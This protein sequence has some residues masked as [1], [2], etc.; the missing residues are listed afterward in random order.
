MKRMV[1]YLIYFIFAFII[2]GES[3]NVYADTSWPGVN[4]SSLLGQYA[5]MEYCVYNTANVYTAGSGF[6]SVSKYYSNT[7]YIFIYDTQSNEIKFLN[8]D[9]TAKSTSD[10]Y[11]W[12][13]GGLAKQYIYFSDNLYDY[14][15]D[16]GVF[17][18][19]QLIFIETSG[20][21]VF[22][23]SGSL[24]IYTESEEYF[25]KGSD[26]TWMI[27][28]VNSSA[29]TGEHHGESIMTKCEDYST[30]LNEIANH[31]YNDKEQALNALA[32]M[33]KSD[34]KKGDAAIAKENFDIFLNVYNQA[35]NDLS[36]LNITTNENGEGFYI[37]QCA[38][39]NSLVKDYNKLQ[40]A[41]S[42]GFQ[43]AISY[44]NQI[45]SKLNAAINNGAVGMEEDL[46]IMDDLGETLGAATDT[47]QR[48]QEAVDLGVPVSDTSCEGLLG[49]DLLDDI[50]KVLTLLRIAVPILLIIL[51]S[52][53][54]ASAVLADDQ[55]ALKKSGSKF[56]KRCIIAVAIFFVPSIIMYLLSWI[57]KIADVSCDIRLW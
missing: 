42:A 56:V 37:Q 27:D 29:V 54:F 57:D 45:K 1:K 24:S 16:D 23:N 39:V 18:C 19:K 41:I 38:E 2:M 7:S 43:V 50:S 9:G 32:E 53:D 15:V 12:N 20:E 14:L 26:K 30:R 46:Q 48:Y 33:A 40:H 49:P 5:D 36:A 51:G 17:T 31:Y 55:Q 4:G 6:S 22:S 35:Y 10:K 13:K 44:Y 34:F 25:G 28:Q 8:T 11:A 52:V 3:S 21:F 47:W